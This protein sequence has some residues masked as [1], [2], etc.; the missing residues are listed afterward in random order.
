MLFG[1][2]PCKTAEKK[3]PPEAR[4]EVDIMMRVGS[5]RMNFECQIWLLGRD[6]EGG[7][8]GDALMIKTRPIGTNV[9]MDVVCGISY[10]F[11][12]PEA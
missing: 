11:P 5:G 10:G 12:G 9:P 6:I 1:N 7:A 8:A 2:S 3:G 4:I